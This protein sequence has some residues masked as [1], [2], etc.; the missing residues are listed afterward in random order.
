MKADWV[1]DFAL[2]QRVASGDEAALESFFQ[3]YTDMLFAFI[4]HHL[5]QS[6]SD[7]E[8]VW[9]ETLLAGLRALP[10]YRG[11]SR[12]FTWLCGIARHKIADHFRRQ[13]Q[14]PTEVFSDVPDEK[15]S[16]LIHSAPM[17]EE[18]VSQQATRI[19][20]IEALGM[21]PKEY[22]VALVM[23]YADEQSVGEVAQKLQRTYKATESLL[24]RA[25]VAFQEAL[26]QLE[27]HPT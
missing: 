25:R 21:L 5:N 16:I 22:Q 2:A 26:A 12:L 3:C 9:Q 23:R 10:G 14:D 7:A 19:R 13:G 24:A 20:V 6:H 4:F 1:E 15:L 18:L 27:G 17:P 11:Q 8:D